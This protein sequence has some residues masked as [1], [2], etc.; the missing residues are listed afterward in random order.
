MSPRP[1]PREPRRPVSPAP[2]S[3]PAPAAA[4]RA[5]RGPPPN[6]PNGRPLP[7]W[8]A[9]LEAL[10]D[11]VCDDDGPLATTYAVVV[12]HGGAI[13]AERY[14]GQLEHFDRPPIR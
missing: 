4:R 8:V 7:G 2:R 14:Q 1:K 9:A 10:L 12:V 6:G 11:R 5:C 13:V 3:G